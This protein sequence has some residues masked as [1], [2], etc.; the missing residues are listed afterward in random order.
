MRT[1]LAVGDY[2]PYQCPRFGLFS[3]P[4]SP[5]LSVKRGVKS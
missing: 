4:L 5:I 3:A 2:T 1:H